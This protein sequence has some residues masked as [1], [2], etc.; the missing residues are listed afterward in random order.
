MKRLVERFRLDGL[1][2]LGQHFV[3]AQT[4]ATSYLGMA[5][6]H[7]DGEVMGVTEGDVIGLIMMKI[8]A[9][10]HRADA[11]L[12]RMG[13]VRRATQHHDA[14]GPRLRRSDA[15]PHGAQPRITPTPE[16]WGLQGTGFSFEM[17]FE[18]GP[19]TLTHCIRDH[20][21]WRMLISGGEI[22]D[23]PAMPIHD[24]LAAGQA[25]AADQGAVPTSAFIAIS[26]DSEWRQYVGTVTLQ[27]LCRV[28]ISALT[29]TLAP[30]HH[31]RFL[32][33]SQARGAGRRPF[34][35]QGIGL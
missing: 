27:W 20:K 13:R 10:L 21:G 26:F 15:V 3:E 18:P 17:T 19:V 2:L 29:W 16:Q 14:A 32:T 25:G 7:A 24:C 22:V 31:F 1:V 4:K 8:L 23:L 5:E 33:P 12:R 30:Y 6:L 34:H 35:F 11:V 9:Q 28:R